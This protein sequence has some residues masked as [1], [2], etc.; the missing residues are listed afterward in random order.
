MNIHMCVYVSAHQKVY[1]TLAIHF[2]IYSHFDIFPYIY[3]YIYIYTHTH[4]HI[5]IWEYTYVCVS[6]HQEA[7]GPLATWYI[8]M[9][10]YIY[11]C[12]CVC[13]CVCVYNV[14]VNICIYIYIYIYICIYTHAHINMYIHVYIYTHMYYVHMC[15]HPSFFLC[16]HARIH[17]EE[18][19]KTISIPILMAAVISIK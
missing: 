11:M 2:L 13:V 19:G 4:T 16:R 3:I 7:F 12:V 8:C 15:M 10:V 5:Y 14:D 1:C 6:A 9:Y 18:G 17:E